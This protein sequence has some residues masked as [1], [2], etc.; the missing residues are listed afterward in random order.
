MWLER[1]LLRGVNN[2]LQL[3]AEHQSSDGCDYV[4]YM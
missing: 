2:P 4:N 3:Y 1:S